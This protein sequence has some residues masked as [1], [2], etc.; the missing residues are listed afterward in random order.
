MYYT[1]DNRVESSTT[2][3]STKMGCA[4]SLEVDKIG[5]GGIGVVQMTYTAAPS[6]LV[7]KASPLSSDSKL[8]QGLGPK[9]K[10]VHLVRHGQATH[11]CMFFTGIAWFQCAR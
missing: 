11:N 3:R 1:Y 5:V 10:V 9:C 7:L 6:G 8:P 2:H 4:Q